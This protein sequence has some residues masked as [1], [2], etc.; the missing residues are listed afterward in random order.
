MEPVHQYNVNYFFLFDELT[1][2]SAKQCEQF[3]QTLIDFDLNIY[4]KAACRS[5]LL[6]SGDEK[7]VEKLIQSGCVGLGYSL[8]SANTEILKAMNKKTTPDDF[9]KQTALLR[10]MGLAV[11]TSIVVGYPQ[12]TENTLN[13]T[14]D[15]CEKAEVY[16]SV[17]YLVPLPGTPMFDYAVKVGAINENDESYLI[18][19][20][21]RQDL[22]IN[23]TQLNN[24]T[25]EEIVK[26]RLYKISQKLKLNLDQSQLIKTGH[27]KHQDTK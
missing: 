8:E 25:I 6:K 18:N 14:F 4:W 21:D 1:F 19:S 10:K 23:L 17:G 7:I 3:A 26:K 20:G 5:N 27:Y 11:W 24:K 2:F 9:I 15:C 16:P 12:E 13:E 22:K